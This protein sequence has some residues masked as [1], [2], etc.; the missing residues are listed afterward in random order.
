MLPP[1]PSEDDLARHWSLTP[2]DLAAIAGCRGPDQRRRFALQLCVMRLHGRFLDDYRHAPIKIVNHLSR[3]LGLPPVL[4]LDRAGREP[5]ERVQA[6]RIRRYLSLSRFDKTA[7]A[8]LRDWLREGA[9]E[10]RSAAELLTRAEDKLRGWR[11]MLPG[12][13]TLDRIVASVM[14]HTTADLF[15]T[16]AGRLPETLRAGID[17]L[18]EVPEGDAR[19][20]LFR[21]KDYPK[22]ANAAVIKGDIVRLRLIEDLLAPAQTSAISTRGSCAKSVSSGAATMPATSGALPSRSAMRLSPATWSKPARRCSTR[23]SR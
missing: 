16:V 8:A 7:E 1:D 4:F 23:S 12:A 9:L 19:S 3:Q 11:V 10:G 2:A 5:T 20:S 21:L 15:A 18:V 17:L 6:Q 13:S 22:S 14:A